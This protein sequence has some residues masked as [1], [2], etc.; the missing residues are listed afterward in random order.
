MLTPRLQVIADMVEDQANVADIGSDHGY[1][2]IDLMKKGRIQKAVASDLNAGPVE[3]LKKTIAVHGL[4]SSIDIRMGNGLDPIQEGEVDT[5]VIAGMGGVLISEI[6]LAKRSLWKG[7]TFLL[8]A[9]THRDS[10]REFLHHHG[11]MFID[12]AVA[13]EGKKY[14][15][16]MKV[17]YVDDTHRDMMDTDD[18]YLGPK[19]KKKTDEVTKKFY[20]YLLHKYSTILKA[21]NESGRNVEQRE[22]LEH[23]VSKVE[24]ILACL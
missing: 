19:L 14:Y 13:I 9:M 21:V 4:T 3:N 6:L 16:V 12:E 1:L 8:Q 24:A 5:V 15:E 23:Q 7:T 22:L 11:F 17:R 10:L 20:M 2:C 18:Y